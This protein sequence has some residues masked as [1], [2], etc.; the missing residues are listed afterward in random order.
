MTIKQFTDWFYEQEQTPEPS[1]LTEK[2][3]ELTAME[4]ARESERLIE[5]RFKHRGWTTG[6]KAWEKQILDLAKRAQGKD[7]LKSLKKSCYE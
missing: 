1:E 4:L 7:G 6:K 3:N 5:Q 2:L